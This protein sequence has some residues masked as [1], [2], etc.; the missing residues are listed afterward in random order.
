M[1]DELVAVG[2]GYGD[3][4]TIDVGHGV[5]LGGRGSRYGAPQLDDERER[6]RSTSDMDRG[7]KPHSDSGFRR[8][9][10]IPLRG[11]VAHTG[12]LP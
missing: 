9:A 10:R 1:P 11:K 6:T 3:Y 5:L 8:A 7:A 12:A 2:V 4:E